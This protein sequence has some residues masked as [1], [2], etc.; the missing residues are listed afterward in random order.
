MKYQKKRTSLGGAQG[1]QFVL[2]EKHT[3][4]PLA[5]LEHEFG[6]IRVYC[7][8][9][10]D[11]LVY[12]QGG[13]FQ[14]KADRDGISLVTYVHAL[15]GLIMQGPLQTVLVIGCGGGSLATMLAIAG[16]RV[17]VV[18]V[19]PAALEIAERHFLMPARV[20]RRLTD[21]FE[22]L[23]SNER[24]FDAIV[25]DAYCGDRIP[26]Q[27]RSA[28]FFRLAK[29]RLNSPCGLFLANVQMIDD[30]DTAAAEY[31]GAA[32]EIWPNVRILDA[33]GAMYRNAIIAAGDVMSLRPPGLSMHPENQAAEI[34]VD[35]AHMRFIECGQRL[36]TVG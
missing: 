16:R 24:T 36:E 18:D 28:L 27:M 21:G 6:P 25:M 29:S 7:E 23:K 22:F 35:L 32:G 5:N 30:A 9:R 4:I 14:S 31:A 15:F 3:V 34:A 10:T 26:A 13:C 12:L 2:E 19:N 1:G 11:D 8:K 33:P 20:E 17:T